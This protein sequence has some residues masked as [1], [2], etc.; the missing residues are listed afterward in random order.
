MQFLS[1]N[2]HTLITELT[3]EMQ[4]LSNQKL[5]EKAAALRDK[6]QQLKTIQEQRC[7]ELGNNRAHTFIALSGND[8]HHYLIAQ[9][10]K[11]KQFLS[12]HGYYCDH[13]DDL[14]AF[15]DNCLISLLPNRHKT[16]LTIVCDTTLSDHVSNII[17]R[18]SIDRFIIETPS[19]GTK[20][21]ILK[22]V[23]MN[24]KQSLIGLSKMSQDQ[25]TMS[26]LFLL[27]QDLHLSRIPS[28]IF[29]CDISHFYGTHIVGSVVVF[30]DGKPA[31]KYYR[32]FNIKTVTTGLSDDPKSIKET[33]SRLLTHY[34]FMPDVLLID[35]GKGQLN[36]ALNA[37]DRA[38]ISHIDCIS[39]AKKDERLYKANQSNPISLSTHHAGLNVLRYVRDESHRFALTFQRKKRSADISSNLDQIPGLGQHRIKKLYQ[40]FK[41]FDK[42]KYATITELCKVDGINEHVATKIYNYFNR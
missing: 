3:K 20:S 39:I 26:P 11:Q 22:L 29:G 21:D 1:G 28:I 13:D 17:E 38:Q 19:S 33:V 2:D 36:A 42:I 15:I 23:Q 27:K 8:T 7:V 31:P 12:Q 24:A 9:H 5:F 14:Q 18:L 34:S 10:Y 30:I 41:S 40:H 6:I 4:Q 37:L 32:H 25:R 35:G 16:V